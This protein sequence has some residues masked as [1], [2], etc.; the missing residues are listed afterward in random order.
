MEHVWPE[1][2]VVCGQ[3][4]IHGWVCVARWHG[5]LGDAWQK[6]DTLKKGRRVCVAGDRPLQQ[7]VYILLEYI[8]VVKYF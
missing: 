5:L 7:V 8:L 6:G 4:D 1:G 3:G 2:G